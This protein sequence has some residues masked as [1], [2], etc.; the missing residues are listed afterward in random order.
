MWSGGDG[1]CK[2]SRTSDR[3]RT[4]PPGGTWTE[5]LKTKVT[6]NSNYPSLQCCHWFALFL[7]GVILRLKVVCANMSE[8]AEAAGCIGGARTECASTLYHRHI[9]PS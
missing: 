8:I 2:V 5:S 7:S 9:P 1:C 4:T 3:S 6:L